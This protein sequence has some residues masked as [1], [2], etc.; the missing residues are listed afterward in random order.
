MC[1][2][3]MLTY[4]DGTEVLLPVQ[5]PFWAILPLIQE[6]HVA[7]RHSDTPMLSPSVM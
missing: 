2:G 3:P 1:Q 4:T 6:A 7:S 5:M